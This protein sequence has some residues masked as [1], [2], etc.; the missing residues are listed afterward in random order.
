MKSAERVVR[1]S[2]LDR[3]CQGE[4]EPRTEADSVRALKA[5]VLRD[6]EWLLNTRRIIAPA[7]P[8]L[9]ELQHSVY[10]YGLP[11]ISSLRSDSP[12]DRRDLVRAV[13]ECIERFEPRLAA[14]RVTEVAGESA[15]QLRFQVHATL[16]LP[17]PEPIY[18]DTV[19]DPS[20]GRFSL[21]GHG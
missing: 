5:A 2:V 18:F 15:R 7:P 10:H 4:P 1:R 3:L 11:D 8:H 20:C 9:T 14:V 21:P 19:L 17:T 16:R 13:A 12:A 6:V